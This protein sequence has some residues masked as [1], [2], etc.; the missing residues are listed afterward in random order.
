[1]LSLGEQVL[2]IG[3]NLQAVGKCS[4]AEMMNVIKSHELISQARDDF[5][6]GELTID[7]YLDL[8]EMHEVN[9]DSYLS[10]VEEN[11]QAATGIIV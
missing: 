7:E 9:M 10:T 2:D 8:V 1:M 3:I 5:L 6:S 4:E 11:L